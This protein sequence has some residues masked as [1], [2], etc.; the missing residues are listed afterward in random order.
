MVFTEARENGDAAGT[1]PTITVGVVIDPV[2]LNP[3]LIAVK[4]ILFI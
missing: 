4:H 3:L 2:C 1:G